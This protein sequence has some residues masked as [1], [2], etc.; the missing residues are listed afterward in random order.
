[1]KQPSKSMKRA[2]WQCK[3]WNK[4]WMGETLKD[5]L[6]WINV[7]GSV[8]VDPHRGISVHT[9]SVTIGKSVSWHLGAD[10]D[11]N[12]VRIYDED[13]ETVKKFY[14]IHART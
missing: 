8:K 6:I 9:E 13:D 1:M 3:E 4:S 11:G 14:E 5:T 7:S 2:L 12:A 10:K